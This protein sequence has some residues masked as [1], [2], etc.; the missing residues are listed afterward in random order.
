MMELKILIRIGKNKIQLQ[1]FQEA[2]SFMKQ[3]LGVM[4]QGELES[5][6]LFPLK[7][8]VD[9]HTFFCQPLDMVFLNK[10]KK[11]MAMHL[12]V[13]PYS[14]VTSPP[15]AGWL[16]EHSPGAFKKVGLKIGDVI[17]IEN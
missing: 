16:I 3:A 7:G 12:D 17:Q 4:F 9:V 1:S 5:P 11:V 8:K 6:V 2:K 15:G 13:K 14:V 10:E